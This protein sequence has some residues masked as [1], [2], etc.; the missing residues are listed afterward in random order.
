M[1]LFIN[2]GGP[3]VDSEV[4]EKFNEPR[5]SSLALRVISSDCKDIIDRL[6]DNDTLRGLASLMINAL[7][8]EKVPVPSYLKLLSIDA[9]K[10]FKKDKLEKAV[11]SMG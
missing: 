6:S 10:E 3:E 1:P 7:E 2:C 11:F 5:R 9:G 8:K 4:L